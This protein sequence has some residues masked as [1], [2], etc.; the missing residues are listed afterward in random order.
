MK[1]WGVSAVGS[2][3]LAL[4]VAALSAGQVRA[5]CHPGDV[6]VD[7]TETEYVCR[8]ASAT[9][10]PPCSSLPA[11]LA[12]MKRLQGGLKR[13]V[14]SNINEAARADAALEEWSGMLKT[15]R[16]AAR[17]VALTGAFKLALRQSL[18]K[19]GEVA[20][21]RRDALEFDAGLFRREAWAIVDKLTR[22]TPSQRKALLDP[23][24]EADT[25]ARG[26][27]ALRMGMPVI[28]ATY[29]TAAL[30]HEDSWAQKKSAA[31]SFLML[32]VRL[33]EAHPAVDLLVIDLS[34]GENAL[35][36]WWAVLAARNRLEQ[37]MALEEELLK[38]QIAKSHRYVLVTRAVKAREAGGTYC[39]R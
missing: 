32:T 14:Q 17:K 33:A 16:E 18:R 26:I 8:K 7:E 25:A 1:Q 37:F 2:L 35:Y 36:G 5:Q 27:A 6:L 24:R 29:N 11:D 13:Q 23:I 38:D 39:V 9:D 4:A 15:S 10:L 19:L 22:L 28:D 31:V 21:A 3:V 34:M 20:E 30:A 12:G